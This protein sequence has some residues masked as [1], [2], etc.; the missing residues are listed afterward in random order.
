MITK[1]IHDDFELDLSG[2]E[3]T[4][5]EENQWFNDQFFVRQSFPIEI[6]LTDE[7]NQ[8][9]GQLMDDTVE[10]PVTFY[11][12]VLFMEDTH[13]DAILE[14]T[15]L[16]DRVATLEIRVGFD[17]LPSWDKKLSELPLES[18]SLNDELTVHALGIIDKGYPEVNYNFVQVFSDRFDPSTERWNGFEGIV[19][20]YKGG[21]FL[22]NEFDD[23]ENVVYNR[24]I[25]IPMPYWMHVLKSGFND[26]GLELEGDVI[27]DPEI[28]KML[29][30]KE[31]E[32]YV[33]ASV[34]GE[35]Y[36]SDIN[37]YDSLVQVKYKY[38]FLN[39]SSATRELGQYED[40]YNFPQKGRY[41][42]SGT[43]Y[44]RRNFSDATAEI[45]FKGQRVFRA[46]E[47]YIRQDG[48][49]ERVRYVDLTLDVETLA[50]ALTLRNRQIPLAEL[51]E[52][53]VDEGPLWNL[54]ITPIALF[55][56][57]GDLVPPVVESRKIELRYCVPDVTFG[58][59]V[60][61]VKNW[62]NMDLR[63]ENGKAIMNYIEPQMDVEDAI[64]LNRFN[65]RKP[66]KGF[67]QGDSFLLKFKE[68]SDPD[69]NPDQV[70]VNIDGAVTD[71]FVEDNLTNPIE[72][73]AAPLPI[74]LQQNV[75]TAKAID[76]GKSTILAVLYDGTGVLNLAED[77]TEILL[78]RVHEKHWAKW[79]GFRIKSRSFKTNFNAETI[80]M[81]GLKIYSKVFMYNK[82]H[83]IR[84]LTKTTIPGTRLANY[85]LEIDTL[86]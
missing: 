57:N 19:N 30:Y 50:D 62:K 54:T 68:I 80:N 60:K 10:D 14:V 81:K 77:N 71:G 41:K 1:C 44:L 36:N 64:D 20:N 8:K 40:V 46:Y 23:Q 82:Y 79:L 4:L 24:N 28:N 27:D 78:P 2:Y 25:M 3:I 48:I 67:K 33:F 59:F 72:I 70:Y 37:S 12:V 6:D 69:Y 56:V 22:P 31:A 11:R 86:K 53:F 61:V 42:I 34:D 5:T 65:Q 74:V 32:E 66:Y 45:Y 15:D 47:D 7:V 76:D 75:S 26:A 85:E 18:N 9:F 55:D 83:L 51:N 49:Q 84:V 13:S 39:L 43:V 17:K 29:F 16:I 63:V 52:Q 58:D 38:G 21:V 73:N 35:E